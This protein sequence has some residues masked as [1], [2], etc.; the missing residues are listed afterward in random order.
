MVCAASLQSVLDNFQ[1]L[2]DVWEACSWKPDSKMKVHIIGV[3]TQMQKFN[4]LFGDS[5]GSLL[6]HH[7]DNL[8]ASLQKKSLSAT[9]G[10]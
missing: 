7:T 4:F 10:N 9:E 2:L 8:S 6:L 3:A 1:V 5:L